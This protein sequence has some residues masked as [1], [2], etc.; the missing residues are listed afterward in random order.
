M[1]LEHRRLSFL[2]LYFADYVGMCNTLAR[3]NVDHYRVQERMVFSST[4]DHPYINPLTCS[5]TILFRFIGFYFTMHPLVSLVSLIIVPASKRIVFTAGIELL[6][7]VF[8]GAFLGVFI[9]W[10]MNVE[11][12]QEIVKNVTVSVMEDMFDAPVLN[13]SSGGDE[14]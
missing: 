13:G 4:R 3:P 10:I 2:L 12:M 8:F 5:Q 9:P 7:N 14:L 6:W 1:D 11:F